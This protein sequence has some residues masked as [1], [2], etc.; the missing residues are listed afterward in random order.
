MAFSLVEIVLALAVL[1]TGVVLIIGL[2]PSSLR[3]GRDAIS[4]SLAATLAQDIVSEAR[5][6]IAANAGGTNLDFGEAPAAATVPRTP[7]FFDDQ[8][9]C[10][11]AGCATPV[12]GGY[13]A[14]IQAYKNSADAG[15]ATNLADVLQGLERIKVVVSWPVVDASGNVPC[16]STA[17]SCAST[18][19]GAPSATTPTK[20]HIVYI[21]EVAKPSF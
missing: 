14:D 9:I 8:G 21:T 1:G 19:L 17:T 3:Q 2:M 13:R 16:C 20:N 18:V 11:G 15:T 4:S 12:V 10:S 6:R 5:L 7:M